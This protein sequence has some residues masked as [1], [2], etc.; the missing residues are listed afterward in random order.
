MFLIVREISLFVLGKIG[1]KEGILKTDVSGRQPCFL[2]D[3]SLLPTTETFVVL[4]CLNQ[5]L[6]T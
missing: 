2:K 3:H 5:K 1:G 4:C 6:F